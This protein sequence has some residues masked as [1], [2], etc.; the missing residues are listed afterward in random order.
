MEIYGNQ[1]KSME[2]RI[3]SGISTRNLWIFWRI[4]LLPH[5]W[6]DPADH[7]R[8]PQWNKWNK[9]EQRCFSDILRMSKPKFGHVKICLKCPS[10]KWRPQKCQDL[11]RSWHRD[12][13]G[14]SPRHAMATR[15]GGVLSAALCAVSRSRCSRCSVLSFSCM[16]IPGTPKIRTFPVPDGF[17]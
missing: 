15:T 17:R 4:G 14:I 3:H 11:S 7:L 8:P 2:F 10:S 16:T 5:A 9:M 12:L 6:E 1:R 13:S